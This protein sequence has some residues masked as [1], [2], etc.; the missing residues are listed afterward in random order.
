MSVDHRFDILLE[1]IEIGPVTARNRFYQVPHCNGMG[2][3]DPTALAHMRGVKAE[4]GWAVVCTEQVELHYSS[5]IT[6]Y[7]E[8]RL[9]DDRDIPTVARMADKI[10]EHGALA[11]TGACLQRAQRPPMDYSREVPM[12]PETDVL[13][14]DDLME[15]RMPEGERVLV[16]D[17]DHYYMGGV[18]AELL[19]A[20]GFDTIY[21][22][23][24][25]EASTWTRNT[26]EQFFIQARLLEKGV[27]IETFRNL[28][29]IAQGTATLSCVHTGLGGGNPETVDAVVLVTSRAPVDGL[30][31]ELAA[32]QAGGW[33]DAGIESIETIG[34]ACAPATSAHAV[35]AGRRYA[36]EL[37]GPEDT[38]DS[39]PFRRELTELADD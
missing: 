13:T 28:D 10:H 3:R 35:Y 27:R 17:D 19:A 23:P 18:L 21:A 22:T 29:R 32:R 38:G 34:D 31:V 16:W 25:S 5:E 12:A 24:A 15:G 20:N 14:P 7:I 6:P 30:A 33:A 26:M 1:P 8:L 9:W 4:G 39:L 36:E 11:R 37:D 2:Y